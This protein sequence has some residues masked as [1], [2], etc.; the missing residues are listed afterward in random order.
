M[1]ICGI[2][3]EY[4]P[5][6][7]G[8]KYQIEETRKKTNCDVVIAFMS[9]NFV[10]RGEPAIIDKFERAKAAIANGVDVVI[11][12][13]FHY[14]TQSANY[15]A[16]GAIEL[17]K[18]AH[19]DYISFG[20]ECANLENLQ[21]IAD[22][23][24]NPD[25][26]RQS[27]QQGLSFP[28]AYSLLTA[29]MMPNDI[30][31]VSY[32]KAI[33]DT[34]IQPCIIQRTSNYLDES[35]SSMASAL[36][37][38]QALANKQDLQQS[39]PMEETLLNSELVFTKDYYPY[40]RTFLL[41]SSRET[42]EDIFLFNEGIER[43]LVNCA[44]TASTYESFINKATTHRYTTG[45]IKRTLLRALMQM[46]KKMASDLPP[47][48]TL[49]VLA[50]NETGREYLKYMKQ[51]EDVK[52]ATRFGKLPTPYQDIELRAAYLYA[53][54]LSEEKRKELISHEIGGAFYSK[55]ETV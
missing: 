29:S 17:M 9:G 39:T 40:L 51:F 30:L 6:H 13:P 12:L 52:I 8:H 36:A 25:H 20:S 47:L 4:N 28:K 23:S 24:I 22:T 19:V 11:E 41:T 53:M 1:K 31:A 14:A 7:N 5:F 48:D 44:K 50:F 15:F 27:L 54:H 55:D 46:N 16:Y 34:N 18:L 3:A 37:I 26:L 33:K 49:R 45:R 2:V 21:E 43:H 10:Q 35:M 42:L 38:R 32:L